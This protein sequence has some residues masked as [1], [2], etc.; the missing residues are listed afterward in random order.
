MVLLT[1][2]QLDLNFIEVVHKMLNSDS[3]LQRADPG[4]APMP[5]LPMEGQVRTLP[6]HDRPG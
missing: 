6:T 3:D 4:P 1:N 5:G 2:E